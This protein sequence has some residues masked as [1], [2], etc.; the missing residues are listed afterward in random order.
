MRIG[1]IAPNLALRAGI[2]ALLSSG[3]GQVNASNTE[4]PFEVVYEGA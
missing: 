2:R 1:V 4:A 3:A